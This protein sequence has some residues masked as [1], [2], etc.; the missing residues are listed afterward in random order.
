MTHRILVKTLVGSHM[1][2]LQ[3]PE[4]DTDYRQVNLWDLRTALSPFTDSDRGEQELSGEDDVTHYNARRFLRLLY[5]GNPTMLE[6]VFGP[7]VTADP[8]WDAEALWPVMDYDGL[9]ASHPGFI[10]SQIRQTERHE[11]RAGKSISSALLSIELLRGTLIREPVT[12]LS[13][14]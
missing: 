10:L 5:K 13:P 7:A 4:S 9:I 3:R 6:L 14:I 8:V 2:G 12:R 11:H 1:W